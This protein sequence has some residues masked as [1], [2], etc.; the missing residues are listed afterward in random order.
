[1]NKISR[2]ILTG[3]LTLIVLSSACGVLNRPPPTPVWTMPVSDQNL[4][5]TDTTVPVSATGTLITPLIPITGE[6]VVSM[7][8][9]F[10]VDSETHVILV[11]PDFAYFDVIVSSTPVSCLTAD[12][13]NG[14]RILICRG[15]QSTSFNLNI[16][17][18]RANCL[19]FPVALQECPP[20]D[21]TQLA[22]F[23]PFAPFYLTPINTLEPED[24]EEPTEGPNTPVPATPT[25]RSNP[26]PTPPLPATLPPPTIEPTSQPTEP[27]PPTIEPTDEPEPTDPPA[28]DRPRPTRKPT[29]TPR[30]S[31]TPRP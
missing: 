27:P 5:P 11:F 13:V 3:A 16:C 28:T 31:R 26:T 15:A 10:C 6:N 7:Q 23:T 22:T 1:M 18:D 30:P 8:C 2:Q 14:K 29:H 25:P 4:L 19:Q 12:V 24:A 17:S 20:L 9:Q 21:G